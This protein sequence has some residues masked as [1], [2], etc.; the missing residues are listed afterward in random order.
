[1]YNQVVQYLGWQHLNGI[2]KLLLNI[3]F[4][5]TRGSSQTHRLGNQGYRRLSLA[6]IQNSQEG[7]GEDEQLINLSTST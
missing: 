6:H 2:I 4:P 5:K 7:Y 1:M 3:P